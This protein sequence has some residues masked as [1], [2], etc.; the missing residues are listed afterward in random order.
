GIRFTYDKKDVDYDRQTYGGLDV[1]GNATLQSLKAAV[2]TNQNFNQSTDNNNLSGNLTFAYK[3]LD[4]FNTFLTYSTGYKPVGVNVGGLPTDA[5]GNADLSL[6]VV[7]PEYVQ[8]YELGIKSRPVTG[9]ILNI[10]AF[11]TDIKDY[12]TNVQSPQLGVNRGYLANAE[13]V[14]VKGFEVD[15]SY[16]VQR[17]L[18]LNA[19]VAY[20]DG[21]YVKFE[22]APLPLEETGHTEIIN[23]ISTQVAFKDASGGR[24][25]GISKW[26]ISGGAELSTL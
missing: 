13:K 15:G 7:K 19:A 3:P 18:T 6:A 22:N 17:F 16:Q 5:N 14:R 10:T 23:G 12:Q 20:L 1:T 8:H 24:L 9:A 2:Y 11:N 26:N 4:K 25:P 21:K